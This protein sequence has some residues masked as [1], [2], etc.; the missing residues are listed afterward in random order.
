METYIQYIILLLLVLLIID[1]FRVK[2]G[3]EKTEIKMPKP[4]KK[5]SIMGESK[6]VIKEEERL[7]TPIETFKKK[8][9]KI[10]ECLPLM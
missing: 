9:T 8:D 6:V 1:R 4:K 10:M 7:N 2:K 3:T 5:S